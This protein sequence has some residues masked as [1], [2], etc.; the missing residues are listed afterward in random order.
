MKYISLPFR[1]TLAIW[2]S[3]KPVSAGNSVRTYKLNPLAAPCAGVTLVINPA[4]QYPSCDRIPTQSALM[5][6]LLG[7]K[8][9]ETWTIELVVRLAIVSL[10]SNSELDESCT[11]YWRL[12]GPWMTKELVAAS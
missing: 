12:C 7:A 6:W 4:A 8:E 11:V 2:P 10:F 3:V 9:P 5:V 1:L